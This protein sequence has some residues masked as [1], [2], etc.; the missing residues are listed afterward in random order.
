MNPS[1]DFLKNKLEELFQKFDGVKIRYE[2]REYMNLHLIEVLPLETFEDNQS[3]ILEEIEIQDEFESMYGDTE[4]ILFISS[5][6]L[7]E[8]KTVDFE[9]GYESIAVQVT[10]LIS[11]SFSFSNFGAREFEKEHDNQY[12][13]AA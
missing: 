9:F 13:L 12:I 10:K 5:D 11:H 8:I 3:F 2:F 1:K 6:S 4:E 7:N